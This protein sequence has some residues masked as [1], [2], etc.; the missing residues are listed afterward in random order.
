MS[1]ELFLVDFENVPGVDLS[2]IASDCK[3]I[4]FTGVNQKSIPHGDATVWGSPSMAQVGRE[5]T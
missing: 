2:K 4:V 3:V 5:W 1:N